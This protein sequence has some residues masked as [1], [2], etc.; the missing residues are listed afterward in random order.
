MKDKDIKKAQ[1]LAIFPGIIFTGAPDFYLGNFAKGIEKTGMDV[2]SIY[3]IYENWD[4][5]MLLLE[6]ADP[7]D[8]NLGL[9][10]YDPAVVLTLLLIVGMRISNIF[11]SKIKAVNWNEAIKNKSFISI[12]KDYYRKNSKAYFLMGGMFF[13]LPLIGNYTEEWIGN[14]CYILGATSFLSAIAYII[15]AKRLD[16]AVFEDDMK[17]VLQIPLIVSPMIRPDMNGIMVVKR[18]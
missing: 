7:F 6:G 12:R 15:Q 1:K 10:Y 11:S 3:L 4:E 16:N 17:Q 13:G 2:A 14:Y 9:L 5:L 8:F 18:F